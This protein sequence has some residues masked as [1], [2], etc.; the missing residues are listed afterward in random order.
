MNPP[1]D[2]RSLPPPG[3]VPE[4]YVP[5]AEDTDPATDQLMVEIYRRLDPAGKMGLIG[6][7]T[8]GMTEL[9]IAGIT[10]RHPGASPEEIGRRLAALRYGRELV[11]Q[12]YGWD[13][14]IHG[15]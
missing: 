6:R 13:P 3:P 15:W 9:A 8:G 1:L 10:S 12:V 7:L 14:E 2:I 4:G 5:Q 11:M